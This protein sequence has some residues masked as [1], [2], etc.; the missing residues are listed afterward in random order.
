MGWAVADLGLR[1]KVTQSEYCGLENVHCDWFGPF[2][3]TFRNDFGNSFVFIEID[4]D[5]I[6][7][8]KIEEGKMENKRAEGT[9]EVVRVFHG[10]VVHSLALDDLHVV[11]RAWLG[12]DAT[13]RVAFL[14]PHN[15]TADGVPDRATLAR[16]YVFL[17]IR[18]IFNFCSSNLKMWEM[19]S[20]KN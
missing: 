1:A 12:I 17:P 11:P 3:K 14:V 2:L 6:T 7:K 20:C 5:K 16:T 18:L 8:T 15:Q 13:G 9:E 19:G 10:T 4:Q